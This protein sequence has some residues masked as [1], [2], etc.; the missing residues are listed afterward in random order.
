HLKQNLPRTN[1]CHPVIRCA[2][3]LA[4]TGFGRLLG[5]RLI[6]KK[7]DPDLAPALNEARHRY[8]A[9]FNLP[10]RDSP[11]FEHLQSVVAES[12]L[13]PAPGLPGHAAALLLAVLHLLWHQHS[14]VLSSLECSSRLCFSFLLLQDLALVDP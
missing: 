2:L 8:A 5:D 6:G 7:S 9:G 13:R 10:V 14:K 3:A 12:Q 11:R 1:H 4:H